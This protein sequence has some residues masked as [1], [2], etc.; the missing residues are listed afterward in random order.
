MTQT[1][2]TI[3]DL[4]AALRTLLSA[5]IKLKSV[6]ITTG[7]IGG[8]DPDDW[9]QI[10]RPRASRAPRT[11]TG[12]KLGGVDEDGA[13]DVL[14]LAFHLG[15]GETTIETVRQRCDE[16]AAE[17]EAAVSLE[18]TIGGTVL[19]AYVSSIEEVD[20]GIEPA[21]RAGH[22]MTVR[23]SLTFKARIHPGR[24]T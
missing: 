5:R 20:Q 12:Y 16:L 7:P 21:P 2:T 19:W 15:A 23:A 4:P 14:I 22:W 6:A 10:Q 11:M 13:I 24:A 18:P 3:F 9:L 1:A 17:V 8:N